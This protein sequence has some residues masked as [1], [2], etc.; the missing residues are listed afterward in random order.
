MTQKI[1]IIGAGVVGASIAYYL[2]K[3]G[4]DVTVLEK[5]HIASEASGSSF[6]W[7]NANFPESSDYFNLR[8]ASLEEY[9]DLLN[10]LPSNVDSQFK[11]CIFWEI[12]GDELKQHYEGLRQLNYP[13]ELIDT[14]AFSE[15]EPSLSNIPPLAMKAK[16]EGALDGEKLTHA[17]L[18][19]SNAKVISQCEITEFT[20]TNSQVT[21]VKTTQGEFSAGITVIAA[22]TSAQQL[23][24]KLDINLPMNNRKGFIIT[25]KPTKPIIN[26]V[27]F[28]NDIHFKQ[29]ED[30]R[31][32]I[33]DWL[34]DV[35]GDVDLEE[36][37]QRTM[38]RFANYFP[39]SSDV[40]I[41]K[42]TCAYR[43]MPEDGY[44]V[45]GSPK[46][47]EGIY[48]ASTHSGVTLAPIIGKLTSQEILD[49]QTSELLVKFR[50]ERFNS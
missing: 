40:Q 44:S 39:D 46:A 17:L 25:T 23:L 21:G 18:K 9:P 50:I 41:D 3:A 48:I 2:S 47:K 33:G 11:G 16:V 35:E 36:I 22:G 5:N 27:L 30:G 49:N 20:T 34:H 19:Q 7:L 12:Q 31:V 4:A 26:H 6:G 14:E 15:L 45:V 42:I 8:K 43:P 32:V 37:A 24:A 38:K 13:V 29:H 28:G 10:Q 1:T